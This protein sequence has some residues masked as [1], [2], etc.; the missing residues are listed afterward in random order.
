MSDEIVQLRQKV[1]EIE[2][3]VI[4]VL[5]GPFKAMQVTI[6]AQAEQINS[7]AATI[8][9]LKANP[10]AKRKSGGKRLSL[11]KKHW[12]AVQSALDADP[13][14]DNSWKAISELT[15]IPQSTCR[16]LSKMTPEEV[17]ALPEGEEVLDDSGQADDT[18]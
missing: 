2:Q 11:H 1:V 5:T 18:E 14:G 4:K 15:G 7:L 13:N 6:A 16:K 3:T 9:E 10:P 8:E 12:L 17:A